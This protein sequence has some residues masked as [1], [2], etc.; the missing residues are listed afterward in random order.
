MIKVLVISCQQ[1]VH[2][3]MIDGMF[4]VS[5]AFEALGRVR[6]GLSSLLSFLMAWTS[7]INLLF[8]LLPFL[9]PIALIWSSGSSTKELLFHCL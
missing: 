7:C 6:I 2:A 5:F 1:S 8:A 3:A 4:V 9:L